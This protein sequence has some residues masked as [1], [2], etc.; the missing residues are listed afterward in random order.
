MSDTN[1]GLCAAC[2]HARLITSGKGSTF[3]LC[4]LS[5]HDPRF[6]KYPVLP[7]LRCPGYQPPQTGP[8]PPGSPP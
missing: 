5:E 6:R 8:L 1:A 3:W 7:V 4:R 2:A